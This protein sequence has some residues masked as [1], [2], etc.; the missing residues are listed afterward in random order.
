MC[1]GAGSSG[2]LGAIVHDGFRMDAAQAVTVLAV[3]S[4]NLLEQLRRILA[5]SR[6]NLL[7]AFTIADCLAI[8]RRRS[9]VVVICEAVLADGGWR[10]LLRDA[11]RRP[12]PPPVIVAADQAD[13]RLWMEALNRGAYNLLSVPFQ[14]QE[15]FEVVS[16]AWLRLRESAGKSLIA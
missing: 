10:D 2:T 3:S 16:R 14:D 6:W 15:V 1:E 7:E 9:T 8:L 13:E 5:H 12:V 11:L 4:G